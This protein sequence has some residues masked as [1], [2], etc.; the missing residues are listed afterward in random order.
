MIT[1]KKRGTVMKLIVKFFGSAE[2]NK[3]NRFAVNVGYYA[4][5]KDFRNKIGFKIIFIQR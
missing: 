2:R 3:K 5:G 4:A 1:G